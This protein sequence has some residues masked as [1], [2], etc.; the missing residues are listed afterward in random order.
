MPKPNEIKD[1][2]FYQESSRQPIDKK[3]DATT[4]PRKKTTYTQSHKSPLFLCHFSS[5]VIIR[6]QILQN[7]NDFKLSNFGHFG[8]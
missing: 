5:H 7:K 8:A 6:S 1:E 2:N 3:G 4:H